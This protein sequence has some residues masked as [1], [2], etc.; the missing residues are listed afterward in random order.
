ME[1]LTAMQ[2]TLSY[3]ASRFYRDFSAYTSR[4]L[5]E[6]GLN[7]G[8]LFLVLYVGRHPDCT[9]AQLTQALGLD[10]GYS[11]RSV[12]HLVEGGFMTREKSGR[13]YH[14]ALSDKGQQAFSVSHQVFLDWDEQILA[15]L[16]G[17]ER[18]QLLALLAKAAGNHEKELL[19][20][21][22]FQT[23]STTAD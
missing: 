1:V 23:P 6:L 11:Q 7:F 18:Q 13:A 15:P 3:Y 2:E 21:N 5:Q 12:A 14:L 17:E 8:A 4:R 10:W 16:T 22:T 19:C 20:T 9:Q